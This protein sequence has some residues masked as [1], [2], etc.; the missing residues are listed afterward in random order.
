MIVKRHNLG[1]A[2]CLIPLLVLLFSLRGVAQTQ[3]P[4]G[5]TTGLLTWLDASDPDGDGIPGNNPSN[6]A[7]VVNW[8][9]KSGTHNDGTQ[10][11]GQNAGTYNTTGA[12]NG[13]A[14][15]KFVGTNVY[16]FP[17]IDIRAVSNPDISIITVYRQGNGTTTGLWGDDNANWDRFMYT[18]FGGTNGIASQGLVNPVSVSIPGSGIP[19]KLYLFTAMYDGDISGGTNHGPAGGSS[20]YFNGSLLGTFSD[21]T[22]KTDAQTTLRLGWDGDGG[23]FIGDIAEFIVYNRILSA[24]E[25]QQINNYL[26]V[27]YGVTFSTAAITASGATTFC[28]GGSVTLTASTGTAYQWKKD[29]NIIGGAT[30]STYVASTSGDYT[31]DITTACGTAT[32]AATTVTVNPL[33][34]ASIT[35][36][37]VDCNSNVAFTVT[38]TSGAVLT[39]K[40]NNGSNLTTTL[41]GG[42]ATITIPNASINQTLTLVSVGGACPAS[43]SGTSTA[44]LSAPE[45]N[46]HDG[47]ATPNQIADGSG[48]ASTTNHTDFGTVTGGSSSFWDYTIQNTGATTLNITG[49]TGGGD[50]AISSIP[51]SIAPAGT[52]TF[53]ITFTPTVPGL[54]TATIHIASNDC[55]EGDYD[56]FVQG[57]AT[58]VAP[59]FT[60]CPGNQTGTTGASGCSA[61]VGYT[62]AASGFPAPSLTYA[63]SGATT[64]SG[65][66]D[67]SGSAFNTG[68]TNVTIT[69]TNSCTNATCSF[70]VSVQDVTAPVINCA[71]NV[72]VNNTTGTC[73]AVVNYNISASDNCSQ[74]TAR[75]FSFTG[76][77][78][79]YTVPVGVTSLV[80]KAWGAGGGGGG[81]DGN[82][83]A[84]GGGGAYTTST[85]SVTPGDVLT[86]YVGGGGAN[87]TTGTGSG[88]GAGGFGYGTG[89]TGGNPGSSGSSG[90]GGGGGGGTAIVRSGTPLILA[91]GGG[92]GGGAGNGGGETGAP[93]GGGG[94]NGTGRGSASGGTTGGNGTLNGGNGT[95]RGSGDGGAGGGGGG[96]L[97]GGT[98]GGQPGCDCGAGGGAGGSSLS[99]TGITVING[100]GTLPGNQAD[101]E[102]CATCAMGGGAAT[103]GHNGYIVIEGLTI[104]QT[105][106]LPSGATFP[107]GITTNTFTATDA[108]GNVSVP[109]SFTVT[110]TDTQLPTITAPNN[111]T[112]NADN[113]VCYATVNSLGAPAT[114]D[115]CSVASVLND[116]PANH[117]YA[118][119]TNTVT[120]TV[121]DASGN[122][123]TAVQTITVNDAQAPVFTGLPLANISLNGYCQSVTAG[124][125][126]PNA[127]DNCGIP[128]VVAKVGGNVINLGSYQFPPNTATTITWLATDIHGNTAT[129]TQTVT[130][131]PANIAS[132]TTVVPAYAM[133]GQEVQTIYLNYPGSAQLDTIKMAPTGGTAPYSY[134]WTR[135]NCNATDLSNYTNTTS[136]VVFAP[137]ANDLCTGNGGNDNIYIY[138]CTITDAHG[139][140]AVQTKKLNV[141]NAFT[142][143]SNQ[144]VQICHKVAVRGG[145]VNQAMVVPQ[146]QVAVHLAHGDVLGTCVVFTGT[147]LNPLETIA[148]EQQ[149]A[150]YP[151]PTTGVFVLEL[152]AVNE[153][154]HIL[155]TDIQGRVVAT[156]TLTKDNVPTATFDLSTLARGM[157][158]IQLRDGDY[159]YRTKIVLQ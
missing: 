8:R 125:S 117:Q 66:G 126:V 71:A 19:G 86:V 152:T 132:N 134:S 22:D 122:Q 84:A 14:V 21:N 48:T 151:N 61:T 148:E 63:F 116:A 96:G 56:F 52:A 55:D 67:G 76:A 43:V 16:N 120:W 144:N 60:T 59:A 78:Q 81:N 93:G 156:K 97:L 141:V 100:S 145:T 33:S 44:T 83:G 65:S 118:V 147:K 25:I 29:G 5:I 98:G 105:A 137:A 45:I 158:L 32:S 136:K 34:T 10:L 6:G 155:I 128:S 53:R 150:V 82:A 75:T 3:G 157:Y 111:I 123:A 80:V 17:A 28:T 11:A 68:V 127:T 85:L 36:T 37:T 146:A 130:V 42:T 149:V 1:R 104:K 124:L 4:A 49:I 88:G 12:I 142:D 69:A 114:A 51:A 129:T 113:G 15:M 91:A 9:D 54:R 106:G 102:L 31:V 27:K 77:T 138:T 101:P 40:L 26:S 58:C 110:V 95:S 133:S 24:C 89:G 62:T 38:G 74:T 119:G 23:N 64:G 94:V 108:S 35:N 109:C 2:A 72:A 18:A 30:S 107:V 143:A 70:T 79:T 99:G 159:S 7:S 41:T 13:N 39:Y 131:V 47:A 115:N 87:G 73:G 121:T 154:A 50:F 139:C 90:G 153:L 140:V 103:A 92:G 46:V 112:V 20:F 135:S 57:T